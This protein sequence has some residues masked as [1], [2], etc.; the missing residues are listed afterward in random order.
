MPSLFKFANEHR[1][2]KD[3]YVILTFQFGNGKDTF[4][5]LDPELEK[6]CKS[7]WQIDKFPFPI[8]LD[9]SGQFI[10]DWGVRAFPTAFLINPEGKIVAEG[11]SG[12][13]KK[14][15]EE[16]KKPAKSGDGGGE[17]PKSP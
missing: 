15:A 17:K 14:L 7:K 2:D 12:I 4:A 5:Q 11:H 10:R 6:L 1:A 13:E 3:K 8:L 16:L 9:Q